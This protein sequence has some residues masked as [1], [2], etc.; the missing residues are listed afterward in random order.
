MQRMGMVL[1]VKPEKIAEYKRLHK[2]VWPEFLALLSSHGITNYTIYLREPENLLFGSWEYVGSDFEA[3]MKIM[4]A[5]PLT[6]K[7]NELCMPCQ[8][9]LATISP[10][11]WWAPMEDVFHMD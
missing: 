7:W 4:A 5:S 2:E 10:G 1:G 9:P 3:D 8:Q 11:E 6:V